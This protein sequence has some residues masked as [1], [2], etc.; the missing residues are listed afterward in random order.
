MANK[1]ANSRE[2]N[3]RSYFNEV[4]KFTQTAEYDK[5]IKSLNKSEF[6]NCPFNLIAPKESTFQ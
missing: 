4:N 3:I 2:A 5:A 1:Q 6:W